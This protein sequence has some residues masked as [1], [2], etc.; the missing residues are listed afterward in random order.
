MPD[1][2]QRPRRLPPYRLVAVE[3]AA[4]IRAGEY[5]SGKLFPS[6]SALATRFGRATMTI[7]RALELLRDDGLITT[8]WGRGSLVVP[9]NER[10]SVG[11]K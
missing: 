3:L 2:D 1:P 6:E 10:P 5:D 9:P 7:R 11:D 8:E 4:E